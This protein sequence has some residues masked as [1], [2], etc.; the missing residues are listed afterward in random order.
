MGVLAV[1]ALRPQA[2]AEISA[3]IV[4]VKA[5]APSSVAVVELANHGDETAAQVRVGLRSGDH[6]SEAVVDYLPGRGRAVV[7]LPLA[8]GTAD[9]QVRV[10][11]WSHP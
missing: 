8:N 9:G 1:D 2:P 4:A 3:R 10:G 5:A 11:G 6:M 7:Y